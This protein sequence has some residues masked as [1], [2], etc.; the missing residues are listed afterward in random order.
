MKN[1]CGICRGHDQ[2]VN[3]FV[4]EIVWQPIMTGKSLGM[5]HYFLDCLVYNVHVSLPLSILFLP[6]VYKKVTSFLPG[7]NITVSNFFATLFR[8]KGENFK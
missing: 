4:S 8:G 3:I 1:L 5:F 2:L 7:V 6:R